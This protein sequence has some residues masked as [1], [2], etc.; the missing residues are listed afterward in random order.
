[1]FV[2]WPHRLNTTD[3]HT[4]GYGDSKK[5]DSAFCDLRNCTFQDS[6]LLNQRGKSK[7]MRETLF[8]FRK[9]SQTFIWLPPRNRSRAMKRFVSRRKKHNFYRFF[10]LLCSPAISTNVIYSDYEAEN[11]PLG[12]E[13]YSS[14]NFEA[15][16]ISTRTLLT[17]CLRGCLV[18]VKMG[19]GCEGVSVI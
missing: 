16:E 14:Q 9:F 11:L 2:G 19:G 8:C 17:N 15:Y 12:H 5:E 18:K 6:L 13:I 10:F 3:S 1:M 7:S 4:L